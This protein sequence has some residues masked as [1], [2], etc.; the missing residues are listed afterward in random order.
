MKIIF[1][2]LFASI[3]LSANANLKSIDLFSVGDNLVTKDSKT[4]LE[5]LDLT[6]TQNL[7]T[8][9]ILEGVG[10]WSGYGF[11][12]ATTSQV[13]QLFLN[14]NNKATLTPPGG[15]VTEENLKGALNLL[16]LLGTTYVQDCC[17][18]FSI[19]GNGFA[20][21]NEPGSNLI[22]GATFGTNLNSTA[23]FFFVPDGVFSTEFSSP[24]MGSYLVR[25][26]SP[27][28]LPASA[29]LFLSALGLMGFSVRTSKMK[30]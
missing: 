28:P 1:A 6:Q 25:S 13:T 12:Y 2:I 4:G 26:V 15:D 18:N 11:V 23:G 22:Y 5:W 29:P 17:N 9:Q 19:V 30:S 14:S 16:D 8:K 21:I 10:G 7:S 27:V 3:S 24:L 20:G